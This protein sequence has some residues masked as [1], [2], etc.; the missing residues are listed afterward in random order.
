MAEWIE[1]AGLGRHCV[2][3]GLRKACA[4]RLAEAGATPHEIMAIGGWETLTE[5]ERYTRKENQDRLADAAMAPLKP[6][7]GEGED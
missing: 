3:H 7:K 4:R 6:K 2:L 1:A 5:V